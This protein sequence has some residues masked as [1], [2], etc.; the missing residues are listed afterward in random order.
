MADLRTDT[1]RNRRVW[2]YVLPLTILCKPSPVAFR[3][4]AGKSGRS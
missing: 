3:R 1:G 4:P 2:L